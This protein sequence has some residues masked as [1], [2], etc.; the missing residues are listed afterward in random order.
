MV[1]KW[2]YK[3]VVNLKKPSYHTTIKPMEVRGM[4]TKQLNWVNLFVMGTLFV[5]L[6]IF[7]ISTDTLLLNALVYLQ[8]IVFVMT[9]LSNFVQLLLFRK[10]SRERGVTFFKS[11]INFGLGIVILAVPQMPV[12]IFAFCFGFYV[13]ALGIT[14]GISYV[15]LK[16]DKAKGRFNE[17]ISTL[18][19]LG[20]SF[21]LGMMPYIHIDIIMNVIGCYFVLY[22]FFYYKDFLI[23]V[24]PNQRKDDF[25][26]HI[27]VTL[28]ILLQAILPK[29]V[30]DKV[31]EYLTPS[32]QKVIDAR[33]D[34]SQYKVEEKADIEIYIHV[35]KHGFGQ[36]GH[37]DVCIDNQFLSYGNYD[38]KSV[39][40]K[41][42]IGDGVLVNAYKEE[43]IPFVIKESEKTLFCFGLKLNEVQKQKVLQRLAVIKANIYPWQ[44]YLS[45]EEENWDNP[46]YAGLL[47]KELPD[48]AFYKFKKGRFK[49][50]FVATTNCVQLADYI[51]GS[52]GLDILN[53]NGIVTP[54]AYYEY[55][56]R[57]FA[58]KNEMVIY[59]KIYN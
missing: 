33:S 2:N 45:E 52:A 59:K 43:Y 28:P 50:Y 27:R 38:V 20:F 14:H 21:F 35:S 8:G 9:G 40:W 42:L 24:V 23:E 5:A 46:T 13:L 51:V 57:Q 37:V 41:E 32:D 12:S 25:K 53:M 30:L 48:T 29:M 47:K 11:A 6:G 31:N 55:L 22:G 7:I 44:P 18:F 58:L 36:I 39:R 19:Y 15:L 26:R 4:E 17:L 10:R 34:F 16:K 49:T 56:N 3:G 1:E 54:G